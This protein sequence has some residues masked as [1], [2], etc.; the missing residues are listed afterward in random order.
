MR[1]I[2]IL[3]LRSLWH[4]RIPTVLTIISI[5]M[6]VALFVGVDKIREATRD[7]F[8]GAIS[9]VDLIVGPRTGTLS[10]LLF[11]VFHIG[12]PTHNITLKAL[13]FAAA[14]PEVDWVVPFSLGDGFHG[15]SVVGTT[16]QFFE[17]YKYRDG[18]KLAY[19]LGQVFSGDSD[20]VIGFA[21]AEKQH[22]SLG[23]KIVLS[24]GHTE[25]GDGFEKHEDHPFTVTGVL[26]VTGTP[27]DKSVFV[28]LGGLG[29]IHREVGAESNHEDANHEDADHADEH[30]HEGPGHADEHKDHGSFREENGKLIATSVSGFFLGAKNRMDTLNLQRTLNTWDGDALLAILPGMAMGEL[31]K[32][33]S[34]FETAMSL[35]SFCVVVAGMLGLFVSLYILSGQRQREMT[36]LRAVGAGPITIF[37]MLAGEAVCL[38]LGGIGV[39][40]GVMYGGLYLLRPWIEKKF[41]IGFPISG[42]SGSDLTF[43]GMLLGVGCVVGVLASFNSYR[44]AMRE[45]LATRF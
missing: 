40:A 8:G 6:S 16:P 22:L 23:D 38:V 10:L 27:I 12:S 7:A 43:A 30:P 25:D 4:R 39:G 42:I 11:S 20:A 2:M 35:I 1:Q 44:A 37:T 24:H 32:N 13:E 28:T 14:Q 29:E 26:A 9:K 17:H 15:A 36:V 18:T 34:I 21:V 3:A 33:L 5:S 45:G 31:W 41:S 19:L